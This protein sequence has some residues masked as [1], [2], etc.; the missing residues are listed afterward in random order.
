M[1]QV[2]FTPRSRRSLVSIAEWTIEVFGPAQAERY[3]EEL[4]Q[5]I[6]ALAKGELPHGRPCGQ[7]IEGS[8]AVA[9]LKYLREGRH[10][11]IFREAVDELIVLDFIHGARDLERLLSQLSDSSNWP[12]ML[13]GRTFRPTYATRL[14]LRGP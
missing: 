9:G 5:R 13:A 3:Q 2:R 1:K 10:F 14:R 8:E 6:S 4:I 7:L 12:R 11:I